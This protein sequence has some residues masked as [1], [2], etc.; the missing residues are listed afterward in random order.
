MDLYIV[1]GV[2]REASTADIKRAYRRLARRFH[3]D[4][5]PGDGEADARFRQILEA[6]ET[7]TDPDRRR[8]YD[9]GKLGP[10]M[11][12]AGAFGF[13]GF[14]FSGAAGGH[15]ATTFGDLFED[16]FTRRAERERPNEPDRGADLHLKA[17]LT[18]DEAWHGTE[19]PVALTRQEACRSCAGSGYHR[20][21]ESR[22]V[23]CEGSGS[24]RSVRGHMVFSK[25]CPHCGGSGRLRQLVCETCQGQ[26]VEARAESVSVRIPAGVDN[27]ARV[28]VPAKGH[29]G[30]R[31][32]AP[33][34]LFIDVDVQPHPVFQ[35]IGDDLH[36]VVPIAIHEAALGAKVDVATPDGPTRL[37]IPPGTQSGQRFRLRERGVPSPRGG[38]RGDMVIEVRLMLPRLLD[39]RSKELLREFGRIN[40]E[41]VRADGYSE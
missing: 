27:G 18:F 21:V 34:D 41:S 20:T 8:R 19:W 26:G 30:V 17:S 38:L 29:A 16:V 11:D 5:N 3:P 35:R 33:G 39:E 13:A 22:C 24:V 23:S 31:G 40:G 36:F 12:E 15:R 6:Y 37:R 10:Q 7:L 9:S 28:R 4:I 1:L 25:N 32:G 2:Q 14:D